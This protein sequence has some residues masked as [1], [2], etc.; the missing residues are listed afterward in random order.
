MPK[1][2][3]SP[4]SQ[5]LI[6]VEL[7][8]RRIYVIRGQKVMLDA[9]LAELYHVPTKRLNEQVKRNPGCFP[10][11]F[12]FR[13]SGEEAEILNRSQI[14]T[15][16]QKH[17]DPRLLPYAS[18]EVGVA[19][20]SSILNSDRAMQMNILIMRAFVKLPELLANHRDLAAKSTSWR[21]ANDSR[22]VHRQSTGSILVAVVQDIQRLKHPPTTPSVL[23]FAARR[24]NNSRR[25][26]GT[27]ECV[28]HN[29][30][31]PRPK[32]KFA[33]L[34]L[35]RCGD[36]RFGW[37]VLAVPVR[38]HVGWDV[39]HTNMGEAQ[40]LESAV[41]RPDVRALDHRAAAAIDDDVGILGKACYSLLERLNALGLGACAAIDGMEN[42]LAAI[43]DRERHGYNDWRISGLDRLRKRIRLEQVRF[44]PGVGAILAKANR[45]QQSEQEK[46][47][48][49]FHHTTGSTAR[50]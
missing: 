25:R 7:I 47:S 46:G 37:V 48:H 18:T 8:E 27:Q 32:T 30:K 36:S 5:P 9:D 24:R 49:G 20:L 22:R 44:R 50:R 14:A 35:R 38:V 31:R 19:I 2:I 34:F 1:T 26:H 6:P 45:G 17:C 29:T 42:V 23:S 33:I 13:L 3:S 21:P 10:E 41:G 43:Q 11:D 4:I 39:Q 12:M 28:R 15:G 40:F 16:S